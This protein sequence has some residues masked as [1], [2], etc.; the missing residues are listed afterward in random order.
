MA[1]REK[2]TPE[3][4]VHLMS[5]MDEYLEARKHNALT[6]FWSII[7]QSW[8]SLWPAQEDMGIENPEERR[9]AHARA[10]EKQEE[11]IKVW[12]RNRSS[13]ARARSHAAGTTEVVV[14]HVK[15]TRCLQPIEVYT[16]K[17]YKTRVA[18]DT[19]GLGKKARLKAIRSATE[20]KFKVETP[21]IKEIVRVEY[22][23]QKRE[24]ELQRKATRSREVPDAPTPESYA[25]C[26]KAIPAQFKA[27]SA[28]VEGSGWSFVLLAGGP[29]PNNGG[30][31]RTVGHHCGLNVH[32]LNI[33]QYTP[34]FNERV[35]PL[36]GKYLNTC[37]TIAPEECAS[38]ALVPP[39]L[40][41]DILQSTTLSQSP[42][43][44]STP[45]PQSPVAPTT[46]PI[47]PA[48]NASTDLD[49]EFVWEIFGS[50]PNS[51]LEPLEPQ[52]DSIYPALL[53]GLMA[54]LAFPAPAL[55]VPAVPDG[56]RIP[57]PAPFADAFPTPAWNIP[58]I[59]DEMQ[60]P[61]PAPV[62]GHF[63]SLLDELMAPLAFPAPALNVPAVPDGSRI[64]GPDA[65]GIDFGV[66]RPA[67]LEGA[68][69]LSANPIPTTA[70]ANRPIASP[71][72]AIAN[73]VASTPA[74]CTAM[75]AANGTPVTT[76]PTTNAVENSAVANDVASTAI[77]NTPAANV[78]NPVANP[79]VPAIPVAN[80]GV[81]AVPVV[82]P[83]VPA[84][85]VANPGVP[86][87]PVANPGANAV[88]NTR[89][90]PAARNPTESGGP[91]APLKQS[92]KRTRDNMDPALIVDGKRIKKHKMREGVESLTAAKRRK[93][94]ENRP[95]PPAS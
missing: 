72:A 67:G 55:N 79:G 60:S 20:A 88:A 63:P 21:E 51:G 22:E 64:P 95:P 73:A 28:A 87:V 68:N 80:P 47:L 32:G 19:T 41:G 11:Y 30:R 93:G 81:P 71:V 29:D 26:I 45:P 49:D 35:L 90:D 89:I 77:T 54:P 78:V 50:E 9:V 33:R 83:G 48:P 18:I 69:L 44:T 62:A 58:A 70:D 12:Y 24:K 23:R 86:A 91:L 37:Y 82:N 10:I 4:K 94:K 27:F 6:R 3:Q 39:S 56:S 74:A 2:T 43:S 92:R 38:R 17:F 8:W 52:D 16:K 14:Q 66:P 85:P 57:G 40:G 15:T 1:P 65:V 13:P 34:E 25:A 46:A 31:I 75:N 53:D 7:F 42:A 5:R 76:A 36:L 84:I 61:G 59:P